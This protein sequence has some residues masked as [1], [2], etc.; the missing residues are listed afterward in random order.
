MADEI[1]AGWV[2]TFLAGGITFEQF[3]MGGLVDRWGTRRG[4]LLVLGLALAPP[5]LH[6]SRKE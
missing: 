5:A 4:L 6:E 2:V 3:L 1:H